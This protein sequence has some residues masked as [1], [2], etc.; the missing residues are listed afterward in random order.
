MVRKARP[1]VAIVVLAS[2]VL[3]SMSGG[4]GSSG[5]NTDTG[6]DASTVSSSGGGDGASG[7]SGLGPSSGGG[8]SSG[9]VTGGSGGFMPTPSPTGPQCPPG[10]TLEC[11]VNKNCPGGGSTTITGKVYDPAGKNPLQNIVVFVPKDPTTLPNILPGTST[12]SSCDTSIGNF[13]TFTFTGADGSFKLTGVPTGKNV[14]LVLQIGK[15]RR[16][17]TVPNVGDCGTTQLPSSGR[18]RRRWPARRC[19]RWWRRRCASI[20][21]ASIAAPGPRSAKACVSAS[22][23]R[24]R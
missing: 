2:A 8:S 13:V 24:R 18:S 7:F 23:G 4:C 15:W 16:I 11:Y 1:L 5:G 22:R 10:S 14:P 19:W 6:D 20:A 17:I 9:G 21:S 12:C 3:V